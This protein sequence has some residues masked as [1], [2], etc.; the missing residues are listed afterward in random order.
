MENRGLLHKGRVYRVIP[1]AADW[2][3]L[4]I[5]GFRPAQIAPGQFV[6]LRVL[7]TTDP[8]LR[9]PF[10]IHYYEAGKGLLWILFQV[11]GRATAM[12]QSLRSGD[13]V[14]LIGPMGSGFTLPE[15]GEERYPV[16]VAGGIGMAPLYYLARELVDK[17]NRPY[18][19]LGGASAKHLPG[20]GYFHG[21]G[22]EPY[23]ATEDGSSGYKGTV[24]ELL[25]EHLSSVDSKK[26][27]PAYACGPHAMLARVAELISCRGIPVQ[28]SLEASFACGTGA[29]KGCVH[30]VREKGRTG[31]ARVCREGPVFEG[32]VVVFGR[33]EPGYNHR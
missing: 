21:S 28:L 16:L 17:G 22:F 12:M 3:L 19:L 25:E 7:P 29:C 9:R 18:F 31:Y 1:V 33:S 23:R 10:S 14:D 5:E 20:A 6:H 8:F 30:P 4:K 11:K 2:H 27:G 13:P 24:A 32:E 15:S 26:I